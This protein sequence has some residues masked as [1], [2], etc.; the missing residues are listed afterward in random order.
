MCFFCAHSRLATRAVE[1]EESVATA[2]KRARETEAK[3]E[4]EATHLASALRGLSEQG[5]RR[6]GRGFLVSPPPHLRVLVRMKASTLASSPL[7]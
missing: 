7:N 1:V 6:G 5:V 3:A 2:E 4:A